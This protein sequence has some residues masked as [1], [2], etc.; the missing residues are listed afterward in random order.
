M[1]DIMNIS[2]ETLS[3]VEKRR[4]YTV[5][6][7]ECDKLGVP[8]ACLFADAGFKVIGVNTNPHNLKLLKKGRTPYFQKSY[9]ILR[10]CLEKGIFTVSSDVREAV[11]SCD[12]I[13]AAISAEIDRK[14]R[15]DYTLL[16][17][18]CK[19]IGMG[20]R[21][22]SLI[23]FVSSTGP[24]TVEGSVKEALEKASGLKAGIDFGLASSPTQ[25]SSLNKLGESACFMRVLGA[26]DKTSLK[27]AKLVLRTIS[28]SEIIEV[29]SI[30]A[31]ET[32]NLIRTLQSETSTAFANEL[33]FLCERLGIDFLEVLEAVNRETRF[34]LSLPGIANSF[35][36][37]EFYLLEE[38]AENVSSN[39][40][41]IHLARK[42]NDEVVHYTYY[43]IKES[44]KACNKTLRRAK[45]SVL[46]V[47]RH[48]NAKELPDPLT[49][50]IIKF[51]QKKVKTV[52]IY[53]PFFSKEELRDLGFEA[54]KLSEAVE[55]TDC[56]LVM[57][58]HSKFK[59]LNL[60]KV[61]FLAK[62]SPAIVDLSMVIDP[63]K[64]EKYGFI[65]RGLGRGVWTQ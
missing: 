65:Y 41:L 31:A 57:V 18:T 39:L 27:I 60:N 34:Q 53:D 17:K 5:G 28:G 14:K 4:K 49:R 50:N 19:E 37:R 56:V 51:I 7:I 24:G 23:L 55:K 54:E 30:K 21:K 47:S 63:L 46:G 25:L 58:G 33:A 12:V 11:S 15:P 40:R 52:K 20:F 61:R 22:G 59:R 36:R 10:R 26:V 35:V 2:E 43:L 13:I 1:S 9:L 48:P 44:L 38:K 8:F 16:E 45:V 32:I 62:K 6:I 64:A 3:S 42:I 29:S